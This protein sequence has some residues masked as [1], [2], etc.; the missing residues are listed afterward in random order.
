[1]KVPALLQAAANRPVSYT[2]L[3]SDEKEEPADEQ[4]A[5][6]EEDEEP[7]TKRTR[8]KKKNANEEK[9]L[10]ELPTGIMD[11]ICPASADYTARDCIELD[12]VYHAYL[13]VEMCIR[14][15]YN[16]DFATA[17]ADEREFVMRMADKGFFPKRA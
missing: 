8:R 1:M 2:H 16:I 13:Y 14:D 15:R 17:D 7:D 6:K 4:T 9:S 3:E 11:V 10:E 5:A 12:G